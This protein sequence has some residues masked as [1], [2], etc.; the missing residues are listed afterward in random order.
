MVIFHCYGTVHQRVALGQIPSWSETCQ[1]SDDF[2]VKPSIHLAE[3]RRCRLIGDDFTWYF[4]CF[5]C[6]F[7]GTKT[8]LNAFKWKHQQLNFFFQSLVLVFMVSHDVPWPGCWFQNVSPWCFTSIFWC[9]KP[10]SSPVFFDKNP[11]WFE[12]HGET[13]EMVQAAVDASNRWW[14]WYGLWMFMDVYDIYMYTICIYYV[15]ISTT[16]VIMS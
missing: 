5:C 3:K 15:Y 1:I 4:W 9:S 8:L 13:N 14:I 12:D 7:L 2:W 11:R 6:F 10:G 16:I